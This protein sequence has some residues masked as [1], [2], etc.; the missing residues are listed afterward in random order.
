MKNIKNSMFVLIAEPIS[1]VPAGGWL[2]SYMVLPYLVNYLKSQ[3]FNDINVYIPFNTIKQAIERLLKHYDYKTAKALVYEDLRN[4]LMK[5]NIDYSLKKLNELISYAAEI[6][7]HQNRLGEIFRMR[8][9]GFGYFYISNFV[10]YENSTLNALLRNIVEEKER[11][12]VYAMHEDFPALYSLYYL[13]KYHKGDLMGAHL[14]HTPIGVYSPLRAS[15]LLNT[16]PFTTLSNLIISNYIKNRYAYLFRKRIL[17][18]IL[19]IS[20]ASFYDQDL[21][22]LIKKYNI[23]LATIYPANAFDH[24]LFKLRKIEGKEPLAVFYARLIPSKGIFELLRAWKIV[25]S[26]IPNARLRVMGHFD[27]DE[28]RR[29]FFKLI[30]ELN[31]RNIEFLGFVKDRDELYRLVSEAKVLIYPSHEDAFSLVVL[32]SLALGIAVVAYN[33]PAIKWVYKGLSNV[34]A[35]PEYDYVAL[36]RETIRVLK[37]SDHEYIKLH[38]NNAVK[39]FLELHSSW[40][41][42]AK[43]EFNLLMPYIESS[44][45]RVRR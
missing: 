19:G 11:V 23:K 17:K 6:V 15:L 39:K 34:L 24:K 7:E 37:M 4:I 45:S 40:E 36:A 5:L 33:I 12:Y 13:S 31:L 18:V 3:A 10:Q 43:A 27:W 28:H 9:M 26:E 30:R 1:V 25:E 42:V 32:E 14:I 35:V 16:S 22:S 38:E 21:I 8:I 2:R 29:E 20:P 44:L 41:N